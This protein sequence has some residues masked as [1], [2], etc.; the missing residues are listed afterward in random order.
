MAA[1]AAQPGTT[2]TLEPGAANPP[3]AGLVTN[4]QEGYPGLTDKRNRKFTQYPCTT[5]QEKEHL[6][7]RYPMMLQLGGLLDTSQQRGRL[8]E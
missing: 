2:Q 7:P 1:I 5:K 6:L 3:E 8:C 4:Q